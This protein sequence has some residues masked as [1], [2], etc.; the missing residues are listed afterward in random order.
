MWWTYKTNNTPSPP[1]GG[2]CVGSSDS[3]YVAK[4]VASQISNTSNL[5]KHLN[6]HNTD[7]GPCDSRLVY[8]LQYIHRCCTLSGLLYAYRK[9]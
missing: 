9:Y 3:I 2:L 5:M 6:V 1:D 7:L 4:V 8:G